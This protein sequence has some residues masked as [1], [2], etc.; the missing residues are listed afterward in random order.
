MDTS[1]ILDLRQIGFTWNQID[2][3]LLTP[4][5][6][7]RTKDGRIVSQA[8]KVAKKKGIEGA[9]T[10]AVIGAYTPTQIVIPI[11]KFEPTE[12]VIELRKMLTIK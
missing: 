10:K 7:K 3:A 9:F 8:Y 2:E 4:D 11:R 6:I 5:K 12:A 1:K